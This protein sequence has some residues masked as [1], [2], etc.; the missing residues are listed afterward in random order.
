MG[1][2]RVAHP[3]GAEQEDAGVPAVAARREHRLCLFQRGLFDEAI[4]REAPLSVGAAQRL[5]G[6]DITED[7]FGTV[8]RDPAGDDPRSEEPTYELQSL[9]RNSYAAFCLK[10]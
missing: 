1:E 8:G 6:G 4:D 9:I 3:R 5:A 10:K 2:H 7:R